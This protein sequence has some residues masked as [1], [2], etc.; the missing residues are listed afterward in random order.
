MVLIFSLFACL[1]GLRT[2]MID[3]KANFSNGLSDISCQFCDKSEPQ[4]QQHLLSCSE[5]RNNCAE[6]VNNIEVEYSDL[7]KTTS[8]QLKCVRL[9]TKILNTMQNLTLKHAGKH[10]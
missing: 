4:T 5:I 9:F 8:R 2:F 6:L 1:G 10:V 3:V 7:F